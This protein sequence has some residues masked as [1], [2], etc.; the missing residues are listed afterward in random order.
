M[1]GQST[2]DASFDVR[3]V[4]GPR[5]HLMIFSI[6]DALRPGQSFVLINDHDPVRLR[7]Q[8][9]TLAPGKFSW[10]YLLQGPEEWRVRI[11]RREA[12]A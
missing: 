3:Q 2:A 1:K 5:R 10:E 6:F 11:S 7:Y 8:F 4:P 12:A 9:E